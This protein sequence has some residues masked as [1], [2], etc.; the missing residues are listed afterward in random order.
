MSWSPWGPIFPLTEPI[1]AD[2]A[3]VNQG[4]ASV[5]VT[6]GGVYLLGPA[7]GA[8]YNLRIRK[9]AAPATPY[10]IT[11]AFLMSQRRV[12]PV[13]WGIGFRQSADGKLAV[14]LLQVST[15]PA[16]S[17]YSFKFTNAT[18]WSAT[19]S[20]I[21]NLVNFHAP[22]SFWRIADDGVNR[23]ISWSGDGIHFHTLHSVARADFLTA[24]EV[25]FFVDAQ[26]AT[27]DVGMQLLSWKEE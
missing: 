16:V 14:L 13:G 27:H 6:N 5:S 7:A 21:G 12:Q 9:K 25:G 3:W 10:T 20:T 17:I 18:T 1:N 23:I 22:L 11:A 24:D 15:T 2:F 26:H 4:G 8:G 19:Y